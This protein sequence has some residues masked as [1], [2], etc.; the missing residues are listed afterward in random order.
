M[1]EIVFKLMLNYLLQKKTDTERKVWVRTFRQFELKVVYH[2]FKNESSYRSAV[3]SCIK[4][5]IH[6]MD[7]PKNICLK[8]GQYDQWNK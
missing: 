7:L 1:K 8:L 3:L 6:I 5:M 4:Y 2:W